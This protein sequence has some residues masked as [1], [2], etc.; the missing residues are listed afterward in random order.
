MTAQTEADL[1][2][3]SF[4]TAYALHAEDSITWR[5]AENQIR[6]HLLKGGVILCFVSQS[7]FEMGGDSS[8]LAIGIGNAG[9][10]VF[11]KTCDAFAGNTQYR[12]VTIFLPKFILRHIM[13]APFAETDASYLATFHDR[14][15]K[16]ADWLSGCQARHAVRHRDPV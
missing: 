1:S 11:Q 14:F 13:K 3:K 10:A 12:C 5:M 4:I 2:D 6:Y 9:K 7:R 16:S 15:G 8:F